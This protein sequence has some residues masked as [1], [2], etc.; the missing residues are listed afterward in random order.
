MPSIARRSSALGTGGLLLGKLRHAP[1]NLFAAQVLLVG[2]DG[3]NVAKW[4]REGA[5]AVAVELVFHRVQFLGAGSNRLL[6]AGID[7]IDIEHNPDRRA[8]ERF[9]ALAAHLRAFIGEHDPRI[10]DANLGVADL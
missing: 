10:T 8:A 3:P 7:I 5:A 2:G 6:V 4:I 1:P 9:G